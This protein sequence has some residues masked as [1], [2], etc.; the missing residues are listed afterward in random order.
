[1]D[2]EPAARDLPADTRAMGQNA[3]AAGDDEVLRAVVSDRKC[4]IVQPSS[5]RPELSKSLEVQGRM[6]VIRLQEVEVTSCCLLD[7]LRETAVAVPEAR[8][9]AMQLQALEPALR[10]LRAHFIDQEIQ[11]PRLR[12]GFDL[13]VP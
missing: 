12:V 3:A 13:R 9:G 1:M 4:P 8:S 5:G 7:R 6:H 2:A 10:L 11:P